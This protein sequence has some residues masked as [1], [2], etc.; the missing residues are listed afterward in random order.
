MEDQLVFYKIRPAHWDMY[1]PIRFILI[2]TLFK[3]IHPSHYI[4]NTSYL[5]RPVKG[6]AFRM[7]ITVGPARLVVCLIAVHEPRAWFDYNY[8]VT[9]PDF[10]NHSITSFLRTMVEDRD[11]LHIGGISAILLCLSRWDTSDVRIFLLIVPSLWTDKSQA[12]IEPSFMIS[13]KCRSPRSTY[14]KLAK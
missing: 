1:P 4:P 6:T 2:E 5:N 9:R 8:P 14:R 3:C 12:S 10:F 11:H 13:K 7:S